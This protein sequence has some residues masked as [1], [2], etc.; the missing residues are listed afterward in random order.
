MLIL[1]LG[2]A[3]GFMAGMLGVGGGIVFIPLF[4]EMV[5]NHS[6]ESDKVA[7]IL[8]NSLLIVFAVGITSSI[9]QYKL[10]NTNLQASLVTGVA[11]IVSSLALSFILQ[12]FH[13]NDP[14]LFRYIFAA[15]LVLTAIRMLYGQVKKKEPAE[16]VALPPLRQFVP[17]GLTAGVIT[18]LT[19]LGG[20][21]IMVPYFN[22]I[23][24]LPIKF[25]T[26]LSLSVIPL[27]ALPLLVFYSYN[28][29]VMKL[30]ELQTGHIVWT[31]AL[32][33]VIASMI[34]GPLGVRFAQKLS[35]KTLTMIFLVFIFT[36]LVKTLFF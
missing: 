10:K 8:T 27:I 2:F 12:H 22:S 25:S 28:Q 11:A 14:R 32:P 30:H 5:K 3:G 17:A 20:G 33:I 4:Q 15:V 9:K 6:V 16:D 19:G 36:T 13:I 23:L 1:A 35:S 34:A 24:K 21:I 26:G 7:Y 29:P 18:S 31:V